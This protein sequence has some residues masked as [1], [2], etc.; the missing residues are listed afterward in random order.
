[1][2]QFFTLLSALFIGA[3]SMAQ[4]AFQSD[5]STWANGAP[6]DWAGSK[7]SLAASNYSEVTTGAT[8]GTSMVNLINEGSSHKRF[9]SQSIAVTGGT[10][11]DVNMYVSGLT[12]ELRTAFYD[13]TNASYSSY[14]GYVDLST[15][16]AGT[17]TMITQSITVPA[18][19]TDI[20]LILSLRNTDSLGFVIDSVSL[21]E[22]ANPPMPAPHTISELQDNGGNTSAYEDS[23]TIT[24][25]VVTALLSGSGYWIQDGMGAW[26]GIYVEDDINTPSRGDSVTVTGKVAELFGITQIELITNYVLEPTPVVAIVPSIVSSSDVNNLED[27]EGVLVQVVGAECVNEDANF[28]QW[29]INNGTSPADSVLVDDDMYSFAPTQGVIYN[30][31][32]IGHFSYSASKLL[33]RDIADITTGP[34]AIAENT[35]KF[36]MYPNPASN[37]VLISGLSDAKVT[38]YNISGSIIYSANV[39]GIENIDVSNYSAGIYMVKVIENKKVSTQKLIIK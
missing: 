6:T 13:L 27:W 37:H 38:I 31:T 32:G 20:E 4:V 10:T 19:C 39:N 33:P 30:V 11:Y 22:P 16:S 8:Y 25:G 35:V 18:T 24:S 28:G 5:F 15:A 3:T 36:S 7:T 1:M 29:T 21:A 9:T 2:K 26:T 34:S 17:L 23:L 12:G 14:N